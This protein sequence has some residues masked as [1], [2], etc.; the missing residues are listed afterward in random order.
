MKRIVSI[1]LAV[2]ILAAVAVVSVS[3]YSVTDEGIPNVQEAVENYKNG[4]DPFNPPVPFEL[5]RYYFLMPNGSNGMLGDD[6][7]KDSFGKFAPTWYNDYAVVAG[8]YWWDTNKL[9]P[10]AWAGY[11]ALKTDV[12]DVYYADVPD[13]VTGLVWNNGV[14]GGMDQTAE[15]YTKAAQTV[16]IGAQWYDPYESP[17]YPDGIPEEEGFDG[18]IWVVDPDIAEINEV[19][20]KQTCGGDWFYYYG[21]RCFGTVKGGEADLEANCLSD[22]HEHNAVVVADADLDGKVSVMDATEIQLALAQFIEPLSEQAAKNADAD[23]DG[24][25]T[26][27]DATEI[28]LV[29]AK[30]KEDYGANQK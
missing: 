27:M 10:D 1:L 15:I 12:E 3:A 26:V 21:D 4:A 19:S 9:D 13:F 11:A 24:K 30:F 14:D 28:Q 18:M 7:E 16:N 29:L 8:I 17:N 6:P 25:V 22:D 20:L 5:K 23:G 2:A